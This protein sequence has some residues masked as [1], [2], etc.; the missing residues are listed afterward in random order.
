MS[1]DIRSSESR[2]KGILYEENTCLLDLVPCTDHLWEWSTQSLFRHWSQPSP[3]NSYAGAS[4]P[5]RVSSPFSIYYPVTRFCSDCIICK[6]LPEKKAGLPSRMH[7]DTTL[8][9]ISLN[10]GPQL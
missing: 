4:F 1:S 7:P 10:E 3:P 6:Y 2:S 8:N 9:Y 5:T